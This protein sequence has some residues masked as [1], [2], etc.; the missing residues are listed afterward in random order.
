VIKKQP[1]KHYENLKKTHVKSDDSKTRPT[2]TDNRTPATGLRHRKPKQICGQ[3]ERTQKNM[4]ETL[5]PATGLGLKAQRD[6]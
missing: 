2:S 4:R 3:P 1:R 5:D 6:F